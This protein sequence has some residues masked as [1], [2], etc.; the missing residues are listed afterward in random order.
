MSLDEY[1][2]IFKGVERPQSL[3]WVVGGANLNLYWHPSTTFRGQIW[4]C[5]RS[6]VTGHPLAICCCTFCD[7]CGFHPAYR[8]RRAVPLTLL[9]E[10]QQRIAMFSY[11]SSVFT[12]NVYKKI[13]A[14]AT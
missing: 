9:K 10:Q 4:S 5:G 6:P 12:C 2:E 8:H 13:G 14:S 1:P 11:L 3:C 7:L